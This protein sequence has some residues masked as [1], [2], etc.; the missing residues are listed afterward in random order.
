[1]LALV[2]M[3]ALD[4]DVEESRGIDDDTAFAGDDLGEVDLVGV[5]HF[6]ELLLELGILGQGLESTQF[7]EIALPA[8]ADLRRDESCQ[9]GIASKQPAAGRDAVGLVVELAGI[10]FVE[11]REEVALEEL[12]VQRGDTVHRVTAD[13]GQIR[14]AHH[15]MVALLDEGEFL[16]LLEIAGPHLLHLH[17]ETLVGL[18]D[19]LQMARQHLAEES[20][21]PLLERLG[22]QGVIRVG[23][24]PGDDRPSLLPGETVLVMEEALQFHDRDGGV[25]VVEL[26]GNLLGERLPV[27]IVLTEAAD[28][29][30]ERAGDE[31]ILLDQSQLLAALGLVIRIE[32]LGNGLTDILV[33][34]SLVVATAVEGLKVEI[35][36]RLGRPETQEVD[37]VRAVSGHRDVVRDADEL[38]G[39]GPLGDIVADIVEDVLHLTIEIDLGGVLRTDDLPGSAELHPVVGQLDLIAV[40]ELLL[41]KPVLVM[42]PVADGREV[43][44][45]ERI[46]ETGGKTAET[47]VTETHVV[48]LLAEFIDI[49]AE[50][51]DRGLHVL[52]DPCTVEA[53]D[54][55][56]P[57]QELEGE[58]VEPLDVFLTVLRLGGHEP[59]HQEAVDGLGGGQPPVALGGRLGIASQPEAKL[60]QDEGFDSLDRGVQGGVES[61][62]GGHD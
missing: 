45:G 42:N 5:L 27:R 41:E 58:I 55:E 38:L 8:A 37:G 35:L 57:H 22:K 12:R 16:N 4:L 49:E 11:F 26:D 31:E 9:A 48:L 7:V 34:D 54:V 32:N 60:M 19:D 61:T 17:E 1:M 23:E 25:R 33:T 13:D 3:Q 56:T 44:R 28:D 40:P 51:V 20:D 36:G 39:T 18:E 24:R 6:H 46:E 21:T 47:A 43:E 30:L 50:F 2:F 59:L 14:H 53:V 52:H 15:L 29:V 10:E 62:F